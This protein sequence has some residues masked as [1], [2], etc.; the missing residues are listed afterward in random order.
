MTRPLTISI[1]TYNGAGK[2]TRCLQSL[3]RQTFEDFDVVVVDNA[4]HDGTLVEV[5]AASPEAR[6]IA[7]HE[8]VGFGRGHNIAIRETQTP[9]I[10]VLNQ[11]VVLEARALEQL[12]AAAH[13]QQDAGVVG[14][15]LYRG[16]TPQPVERIDT[17]G[18]HKSFFYQ[19][20]DRG[21]GREV[22]DRFTRPGFVW[23]ISG[24]CMLLRR[25]AIESIAYTRS[26]GTKE[27]FDENFFMYKEDL[28][29]CARL[30]RAGFKSW[31]EP[32]AL[33]WHTRTGFAPS[34]M[35]QVTKH[36]AKLPRYVRQYSYRNHWLFILKNAP[37]LFAPFILVYELLKALYLL[38][39]ETR[40]LGMILQ[41]FPLLPI[42][43]ARRYAPTR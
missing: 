23:G 18:L 21:T 13:A 6:V 25:S 36:R 26:D 4:S 33:G 30:N 41:V 5:D 29:L 1:V 16:E 7:L 19:V 10:L 17:A 31:Y 22:S 35:T 3:H 20:V 38:V 42:M 11:D 24:S 39:F 2:I 27:Y 43:L 15:C 8:N 34:G 12:M 28:D 32:R 37:L 40:T 14:P 9:F